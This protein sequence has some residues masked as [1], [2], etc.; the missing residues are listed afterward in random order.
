MY[1]M[2]AATIILVS[3]IIVLPASADQARLLTWKDLIPAHLTLEDT[4]EKLNPEQKDTLYWVVNMLERLPG[5]GPETDEFY[6]EIDKAIPELKAAGI[7]IVDFMAKRKKMRTA[8]DEKLNGQNVR[9][10]GYL[11]PLDTSDGKVTEFL[12][13]PYIGACIHV[14]PPPPNQI[15]Y[16]KISQKGSYKEKGGYKIEK[17]YEPVFVTG[18]IGVKSI[19]KELYLTDGSAGID[20]G[21]ALEASRIEPYKM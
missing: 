11:L 3:T 19:V 1:N 21:Y 18:E 8:V 17:L 10:A 15:I 13:V 4:I 6:Q 16:V 5:R 20:I 9:I 7:D 12:L 2:L 14:P